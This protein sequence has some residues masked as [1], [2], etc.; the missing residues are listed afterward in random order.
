M[1]TAAIQ[2]ELES[3][4]DPGHAWKYGSS[5]RLAAGRDL[6]LEEV[7]DVALAVLEVAG[8]ISVVKYDDFKPENV[9]HHRVKFLKRH[10]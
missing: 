6:F 3:L 7:K 4:A 2:D 8:Y 5:V 1:V 9:P 10:P